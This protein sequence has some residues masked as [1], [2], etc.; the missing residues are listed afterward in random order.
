MLRLAVAR[1]WPDKAT[2]GKLR[3]LA[4]PA[5]TR[6]EA[7]PDV[8]TVAQSGYKDYEVEVWFG[9][10]APANTPKKTVSELAGWFTAALRVPE[11]KAKLATL[12]LYPVGMCGADFGAFLRKQ[13]DEFGRAIR[14][15][16]NQ[17]GVILFVIQ[18]TA[19]SH[20]LTT[21]Q[22]SYVFFRRLR[23]WSAIGVSWSNGHILFDR[24]RGCSQRVGCLI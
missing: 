8:P 15:S 5:R 9:L 23:T 19:S 2:A 17:G 21:I 22:R 10:V 6:I 24:L 11:V 12:G 13:Y 1:A 14:E 3:A 7:L 16:N 20:N 18:M 4:T